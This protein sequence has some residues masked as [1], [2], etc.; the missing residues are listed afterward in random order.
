MSTTHCRRDAPS[1]EGR[2]G[3]PPYTKARLLRNIIGSL[4]FA[5]LKLTADPKQPDPKMRTLAVFHLCP[6]PQVPSC[7]PPWRPT[8]SPIREE[9]RV[10]RSLPGGLTKVKPDTAGHPTYHLTGPPGP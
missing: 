10:S 8:A 2:H 6:C 5:P 4:H 9:V 7:P 1:N 3:Q